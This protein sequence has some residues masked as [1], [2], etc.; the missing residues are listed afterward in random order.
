VKYVVAFLYEDFPRYNKVK[1]SLD[2]VEYFCD[3]VKVAEEPNVNVLMMRGQRLDIHF[4]EAN[5]ENEAFQEVY[6]AFPKHIIMAV[7]RRVE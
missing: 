4:V 3:D 7:A 6:K 1:Q 2:K 5:D